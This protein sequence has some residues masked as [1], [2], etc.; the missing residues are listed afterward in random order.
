MSVTHCPPGARSPVALIPMNIKKPL[1]GFGSCR[2]P[3]R[4]Q[5]L[6]DKTGH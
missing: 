6:H 2:A 5:V 3:S 1:D 4:L